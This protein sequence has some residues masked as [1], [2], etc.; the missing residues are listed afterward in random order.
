MEALLE[1]SYLQHALQCAA[2]ATVLHWQLGNTAVY[3][4]TT[5]HNL[6]ETARFAMLE[7]SG[8]SL[9]YRL[10]A[11]AK[12]LFFLK[13]LKALR[14]LQR[15]VR[16]HF[17]RQ[18][19]HRKRSF[20]HAVISLQRRYRN[21]VYVKHVIKCMY[22]V[23]KAL[24]CI[25]RIARRYCARRLVQR[26]R[27]A[28]DAYLLSSGNLITAKELRLARR[29]DQ[30]SNSTNT[31]TTIPTITTKLQQY[32][33]EEKSL[34]VEVSNMLNGTTTTS[35]NSMVKFD[36]TE[37]KKVLNTWATAST[38]ELTPLL[39]KLSIHIDIGYKLLQPHTL[40][41][42]L[43]TGCFLNCQNITQRRKNSVQYANKNINK[44]HELFL[45]IN[46]LQTLIE[47]ILRVSFN[48]RKLALNKVDT[49][50]KDLVQNIRKY[51]PEFSRTKATPYYV[52]IQKYKDFVVVADTVMRFGLVLLKYYQ[53]YV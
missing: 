38:P 22:N 53:G 3:M 49:V 31:T 24:L 5:D 19:V 42:L 30:S 16:G 18:K 41:P 14:L 21:K 26:L 40:I 12:R 17:A 43:D 28:R 27:K 15:T 4:T 45:I 10:N 9:A 44:K 29:S 34:L 33:T 32:Y 25:Q 23:Y 51:G 50:K 46:K 2:T 7:K 35:H 48:E 20:L 8:V 47:D 6:L 52:E 36:V 37:T 13:S 39:Q 11:Y 1:S